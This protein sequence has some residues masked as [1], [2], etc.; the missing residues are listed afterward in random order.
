MVFYCTLF[1]FASLNLGKLAILPG[2][3]IAKTLKVN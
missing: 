3:F 2:I 1:T